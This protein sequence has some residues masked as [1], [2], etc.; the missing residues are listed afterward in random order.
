MAGFQQEFEPEAPGLSRANADWLG[1]AA[2]LAY[3]GHAK[4]EKELADWGMTEQ[5]FVDVGDTEGFLATDGR[6]A[7]LVFRGTEPSKVHD[8]F[9]DLKIRQVKGPRGEV[10]R[11]FRD[12]LDP[13]WSEIEAWLAKHAAKLPLFI[14][15]HSLGGALAVLATAKRR[16]RAGGGTPLPVQALY[17]FGQPRVGDGEFVGALESDFKPRWFRYV[18][19]NDVVPRVPLRT[20]GYADGGVVRWFDEDGDEQDDLGFWSKLIDRLKGRLKDLLR[21][22]TDGMKD[23]S[24]A[25]YLAHL[26]TAKARE[27]RRAKRR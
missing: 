7:L 4:V 25:R 1:R 6:C 26:A 23:H 2:A 17:T 9:T 8:W 11:G 27:Q 22:G 13:A 15:G 16:L 5:Q 21:P 10:H 18:N 24:M 12:A 14:T 20:M 3:E 19:H